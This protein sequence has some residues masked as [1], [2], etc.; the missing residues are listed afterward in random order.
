MKEATDLSNII[1]QRLGLSSIRSILSSD[2]SRRQKHIIVVVETMLNATADVINFSPKG[3]SLIWS[4][5][6][7]RW[8]D[9]ANELAP[10]C[11]GCTNANVTCT[12]TGS[13]TAITLAAIKLHFKCFWTLFSI[14]CLSFAV[15]SSCMYHHRSYR[16]FPLSFDDYRVEKNI[17]KRIFCVPLNWWLNSS[18]Q[19]G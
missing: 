15:V 3:I 6:R 12:S 13:E 9:D 14:I 7:R 11:C 16:N 18:P 1:E 19:E 17:Q 5:W 4:S 10:P 2:S 8:E